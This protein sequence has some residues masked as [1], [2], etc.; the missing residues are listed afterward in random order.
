MSVPNTPI[1]IHYYV[2]N[3]QSFAQCFIDTCKN[4]PSLVQNVLQNSFKNCRC[5]DVYI[6]T[7]KA[8]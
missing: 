4:G 5:T 1:S 6:C 3:V 8:S 2:T 7:L